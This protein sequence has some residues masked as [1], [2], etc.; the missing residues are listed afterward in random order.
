V[1][2]AETA[3]IEF[4]TRKQLDILGGLFQNIS[5]GS[6]FSLIYSR[7]DIG[8]DEL[9]MVRLADPDAADHRTFQGQS[10]Y[11]INLNLNY[12]DVEKGLTVSVY[13]NRFGERLAAV[14]KGVTPDIYEQP[15]DLLNLSISK[16]FNGHFSVKFAVNNILNSEQKKMHT[17]KGTD[18]IAN[19]VRMGRTF[20][21]SFKYVI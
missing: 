7:V 16:Q 2:E 17:F 11:L 15:A 3:G 19:L 20:S 6:N 12:D 9:E 13:Y 10:P 14:G 4:E 8:A 1:N 5:L 21:L 18:Y